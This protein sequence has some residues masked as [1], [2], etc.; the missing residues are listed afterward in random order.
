M[1]M[2]E[3]AVTLPA[4]F[5]L[6]AATA[7][8]Q[9]EGAVAED[10]RLPSVW[11]TF[12]AQPGRIADDS[13]G[14][15]A[16]DHYHRYREDIALMRDLGATAYEFSLAWSRIQPTGDG[17][18]NAAGLDFY[19]RLVDELCAAGI[20]PVAT[21][22]H[23]DHPQPVEDAG[24]WQNRDTG[25]RLA[26]YATL[27]AERLADRVAMWVTMNEPQVLTLLGYA[28]G[29]HAPGQELGFGALPVAHHL[30]LGHGLAARAL[31]A[32]G[33]RG[34]G[35]V[36]NHMPVSPAT[37]SDADKGAADAYNLLYNW[38]FVDPVLLGRYPADE[39]AAAMPGPVADDLAV[40]STPL[41]FYGLNYYMPARVAAPGT[42][43][44]DGPRVVSGLELPAGLPFE[45]RGIE[46]VPV[47]GF[48]WPVVPDGLRQILLAFAE[49]YG[50]ALPPIHITE[51]GCS[52]D[53]RPDGTGRVAD[54][55]RIAY[56]DGHLRALR[57]A[58]DAGVDVR[59]YFAWSM[60]DNFEW[61]EGFTQRFGLVH[62]DYDTQ[63][64]TPKDSYHW[65]RRLIAAQPGGAR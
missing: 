59:G 53:D 62:V 61:A 57:A 43:T 47:T 32:A 24:G 31:R 48:G 42:S 22:Y 63:V 27:A 16:C 21:L 33:A 30:L 41:D 25:R 44:S 13:S 23:W 12:C 28:A 14:V 3:D 18:A 55:R 15:V 38:L 26:E 4:G 10:G 19:D 45:L 29:V 11:D 5:L 60:M 36:G 46:D 56:H 65:Y 54:E 40:I 49:R 52:Y 35:L 64:R 37:G 2:T 1:T 8:Y 9:I 39:L 20:A 7:A 58:M 34:V 6:G 50:D 51:N 17:P